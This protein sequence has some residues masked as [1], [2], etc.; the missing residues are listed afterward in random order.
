MLNEEKMLF[1]VL[2]LS[3][4]SCHVYRKLLLELLPCRRDLC[5][6]SIASTAAGA[7]DG[8]GIKFSNLTECSSQN[9]CGRERRNLFAFF[10][11]DSQSCLDF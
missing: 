7:S 1:N 3:L 8:M 10:K 6:S 5:A 11:V 2:S 4:V 9:E